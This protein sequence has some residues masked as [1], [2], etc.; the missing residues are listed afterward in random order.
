VKNQPIRWIVPLALLFIVSLA[1]QL[2]SSAK[3]EERPG[4][5]VFED[6]FGDPNSGWNRATTEDGETDYADGTYRILVNRVNMDIWA[7]PGQDFA[8][9]RVEVTAFKV[10]GGNNNRFGLICR[11]MDASNFYTFVISSD[12]FFGIG[13]IKGEQYQLIGMQALQPSKA[14]KMGS[15]VNFLRAD[16]IGTTLTFYANGEKLAEVQ[17]DEF[18]YGDAGLIAG[19]Y[20]TPGVDVR[21]DDFVV[22]EP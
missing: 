11:A 20:D 6:G 10:E 9:V 1:C 19:T 7:K 4:K 5:I 14:I 2:T 17:D 21:F 12:G 16:C 8:D 15:S 22:R 13:K 3:G 18:E